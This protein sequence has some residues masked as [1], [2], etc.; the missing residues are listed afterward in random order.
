VRIKLPRNWTKTLCGAAGLLLFVYLILRT[1]VGPLLE[2][3]SRFGIW[4]PAIL[5]VGASWLFFQACAWS[6]IQNAY[7]RKVPFG[8]LLCVRVI[9]DALNILLPSA[10]LGGD[11]ARAY[12]IKDQT[13]LKE[14]IAGVL[15]DKTIEFIASTVFL[16]ASL[17]LGSLFIKM[18]EGLL[19]PTILCLIVTTAG[20]FFL[21]FFSARGFYDI[22]LRISGILPGIKRWVIHREDKIKALEGNLR[23]LYRKGNLKSLKLAAALGFH[24]LARVAG[25]V[26]VLII[27]RVLGARVDFIQAF[28]IFTVVVITNTIFFLLPGQWGITESASI[29][30]LQSLGYPAALGLSLSVIRRIRK[31]AFVA[32]A[33]ILFVVEK[34]RLPEKGERS[35]AY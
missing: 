16:A 24:F 12:M 26:E 6:I 25:A 18:P 7:F 8:R 33:L 27:L 20:L 9:G 23:L 3:L 34:K 17:L 2:N 29:L 4:F 32:L 31:L 10:S 13:P 5:A 19:A 22:L 11:A 15:F 1:G 28:F 14:G 35:I 30:V 21:V